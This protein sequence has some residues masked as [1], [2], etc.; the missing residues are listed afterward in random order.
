MMTY[1]VTISQ[2]GSAVYYTV[3]NTG[4]VS[5]NTTTTTSS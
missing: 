5:F 3:S 2:N 4:G 1:T